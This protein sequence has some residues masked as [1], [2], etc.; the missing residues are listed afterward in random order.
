[1][2]TVDI[3][4]PVYN[5]ERQLAASART[6]LA[7]CD[8]HPEH[9]WRVVVADNGSTDGTLAVAHALE[10]EYPRRLV[11]LHVPVAGRGLA[12]RTAWLTSPAEVCAYMD[13]DLATD[14]DALPA[15][16][17][18]LAA[19]EADLAVGSRLHPDAQ[20]QRSR[21]RELLSRGFVLVLRH[22]LGLRLSDA[23]CGFKAIRREAA[24]ELIPLVRDNRWF[25]DSELLVLAQRNEYRVREVPVRWTDDLRSSVR[26]VRTVLQDAR[27]VWRLRRGGLPQVQRSR[28]EAP[29]D[30]AA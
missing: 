6:L 3:V 9:Q 17:E 7:W 25:F 1:M 30:R 26:I 27:G 28:S 20:R 13:V 5:E 11:A 2:A 21:R 23:Q 16:I 29:G 15:L 18:P 12:L 14:L 19:N 24:R 22:G 8:A 10:G 4:L